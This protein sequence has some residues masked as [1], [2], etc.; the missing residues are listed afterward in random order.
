MVF[1]RLSVAVAAAT[2]LFLAAGSG[3]ALAQAEEQ[4]LVDKAK[5]TISSFAADPNMQWMRDNMKKAK[6]VLIV[7]SMIKGGFFIGGSGGSGVLL[8]RDEATGSWGYPAFY[9][10]GSVSFGLQIGGEVAEIALMIMT[11]NG[12]DAML[13]TEAKLGADTSIAVGPM[14]AGGKAQTSDVLAFSRAKGLYG[15][16]SAEGAIVEPRD[17]WNSAYYGQK[18]RPIDILVHRKVSNPQADPLREAVATI[19]AK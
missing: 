18:I 16:I 11:Q 3:P 1:K 2:C 4:A 5:A 6:G 10:M 7:P 12:L 8:I 19:A 13:S 14:G 15:G 17:D 9:T